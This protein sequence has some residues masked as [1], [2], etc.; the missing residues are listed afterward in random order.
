MIIARCVIESDKSLSSDGLSFSVLSLSVTAGQQGRCIQRQF[1]KERVILVSF[2]FINM[3][4]W[5]EMSLHVLLFAFLLLSLS[6]SKYVSNFSTSICRN[7]GKT[8]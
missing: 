8:L 5:E 3:S 1:A 2:H 7:F 6:C 4:K